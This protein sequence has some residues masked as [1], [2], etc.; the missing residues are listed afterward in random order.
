MQLR[1]KSYSFSVLNDLSQEAIQLKLFQKLRNTRNAAPHDIIYETP[2]KPISSFLTFDKDKSPISGMTRDS[3]K[4]AARLILDGVFSNIKDPEAPMEL[5]RIEYAI[6]YPHRQGSAREVS[7]AR[8]ESLVRTFL[9]AS[10][11]AENNPE[12]TLNGINVAGYYR[13]QLLLATAPDGYAGTYSSFSKREKDPVVQQTVECGLLVI[14]LQFSKS[15][16]WDTYTKEEQDQVLS[17]IEG[18]AYANIPGQNWILFALLMMAF[19]KQNGRDVD[20][21]LVHS[22]ACRITDLYAGNGWYRDGSHFDYYN[23][24]AFQ[25]F[26]PLWCVWYGDRYEPRAASTIREASDELMRHF[27]A[28]FSEEGRMIFYGRSSLYRCAH[29]SAIFGNIYLH[30]HSAGN[31]N[32]AGMPPGKARALASSVLLRFLEHKELLADGVLSPGLF[33]PFP[34]V[35]QHYSCSASAYWMGLAFQFLALPEDHQFWTA[36]EEPFFPSDDYTSKGSAPHVYYL[37]E[38]GISLSQHPRNGSSILRSGKVLLSADVAN[39]ASLYAKI[40][41]HSDFPPEI[42]TKDILNKYHAASQQYILTTNSSGHEFC[43]AVFS[44]GE[45]D[46]ILYR[47][48]FFSFVPWMEWHWLSSLYTADI[49][50]ELGFIQVCQAD[51]V[52]RPLSLTLGS[53]GFPSDGK[54]VTAIDAP[55]D[56][57]PGHAIILNNKAADGR[58]LQMAMT[59]WG[60]WER[61]E[62]L[63]RTGVNPLWK[64][65]SVIVASYTSDKRRRYKTPLLI[66]QFIS[67]RS[68]EPF[69]EEELFPIVSMDESTGGAHLRLEDGI[70]MN[71]DFSRM[72]GKLTL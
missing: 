66:S 22:Y 67:K 28:L 23:L 13:K 41:Y 30:D 31:E 63:E 44:C 55:S 29:L 27:P 58:P 20:D 64:N 25:L 57:L 47:R 54:T 69:T 7:A 65:T 68:E 50:V 18:Y 14:A 10:A 8:F 43:N 5:P 62:V 59:V 45:N 32:G 2:E 16:I 37:P 51:P 21:K 60:G 56:R 11:A 71:I 36:A 26:G 39:D 46:R 1:S 12:L 61:A 72:E 34:P 19:L 4:Q 3:W 24:W 48:S 49:P 17:F 9:I 38:P 52:P 40:S 70:E 6:T 42:D 15:V 53:W 35:L 33:G